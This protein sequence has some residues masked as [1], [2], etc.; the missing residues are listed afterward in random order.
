MRKGLKKR[1]LKDF[2][3]LCR[4]AR[5]IVLFFGFFNTTL[6]NLAQTRNFG[7]SPFIYTVKQQSSLKLVI[8]SRHNSFT[9]KSSKLLS[10]RFY[11]L[12]QFFTFHNKSWWSNVLISFHNNFKAQVANCY[13]LLFE[14]TT[15]GLIELIPRRKS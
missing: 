9:T 6:I 7:T 15:Y 11:S 2:L 4:W 14:F 8:H 5:T 3:F 1:T 13:W 10:Y 12:Q